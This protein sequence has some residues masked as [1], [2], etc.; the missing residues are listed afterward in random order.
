[1][2]QIIIGSLL[3]VRNNIELIL[4]FFSGSVIIK[5]LQVRVWNSSSVFLILSITLYIYLLTATLRALC[6]YEENGLWKWYDYIRGGIFYFP[7]IAVWI[8]FVFAVSKIINIAVNK[9]GSSFILSYAGMLF[10]IG[11]IFFTAFIPAAKIAGRSL[12]QSAEFQARLIRNNLLQLLTAGIYVFILV[13]LMMMGTYMLMENA[14]RLKGTVAAIFM[15]AAGELIR[16]AT[17]VVILSTFV[18]IVY[19]Q[20]IKKDTNNIEKQEP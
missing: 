5:Y 11:V 3:S 4:L 15:A 20:S 13:Q 8:L 7:V 17:V 2:Q 10:L 1:M 14:F 16:S 9:F 18:K 6:D 12:K 19:D